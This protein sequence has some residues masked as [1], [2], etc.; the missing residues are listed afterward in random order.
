MQTEQ[1]FR[2]LLDRYIAGTCTAQEKTIIEKWF[3]NGGDMRKEDLNLSASDKSRLLANIH[4]LQNEPP[5]SIPLST[6]RHKLSPLHSLFAGWRAAALWAGII[7]T[8]G[9]S[10]WKAGDAG[11]MFG[12]KQSPVAFKAV[13]TGRAEVKQIILPDSSVVVLNANS[14]LKYHPD[15]INHRQLRLS[16]EALFTVTRD[17]DHPFTV[18]TADSLATTVLGTQF[19]ISSYDKAEDVHITVS[20]GKV[21]VSKPGSALDTLTKA[22]AIRYNRS[23]GNFTVFHDVAIENLSS[24]AKGEWVYE[25]ARFNDLAILLQNHYGITLNTRLQQQRLQTQVN[26]NF[27]KK[28]SATEIMEVFCSFAGCRFRKISPSEMEIY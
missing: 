27:N 17:K 20:S 25:N 10:I 24:W 21:S 1:R 19:N 16:G 28:Q 11:E 3:E 9:I 12:S 6:G 26:V 18:L 14:T 4:R 13:S 8:V 5:Q 15:F 23:A 7:L 2:E 22:Q